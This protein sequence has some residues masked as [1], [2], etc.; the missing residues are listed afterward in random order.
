MP[1]RF[2]HNETWNFLISDLYGKPIATHQIPTGSIDPSHF[3][4]ALLEGIDHMLDCVPGR[5]LPLIGI[6]TPGLVNSTRSH[7]TRMIWAG[8]VQWGTVDETYRVAA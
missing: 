6:G 3:I 4:S 2:Y 5:L 8:K 7:L 1:R